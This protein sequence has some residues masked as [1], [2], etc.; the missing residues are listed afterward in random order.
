MEKDKE[1]E[2]MI[3]Q[4]KNRKITILED[5]FSLRNISNLRLSILKSL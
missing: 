2:D 3:I 5:E 4:A 1:K